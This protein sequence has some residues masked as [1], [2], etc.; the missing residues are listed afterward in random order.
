MDARCLYLAYGPDVLTHCPFCLS[1]EPKTYF[2]Y[3]LPAVLLPHLLHLF[4]LGLATSSAFTGKHG[5]RWRTFAVVSGAAVALAECYLLGTYD[6]KANARVIRPE[7]LDHFHW[8]MR[9]LR[10]I[11]ICILD[12]A[13]AGLVWGTSTNRIFATPPTA[14]ERTETAVN[15][16]DSVRGRLAAAGILRN[17]VVRDE[18]LRSKAEAYWRREKEVMSEVMDER[19]VVEGIRNA[20]SGRINLTKIEADAKKYTDGILGL[21][22]ASAT[23]S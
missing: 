15:A 11:G 20:L 3:A 10:G 5:S 1:D 14:A 4:A 19:E 22:D 13:L 17:A 23:V 21:E 9:T 2:Y 7:D 8:R 12:S 6:F 16:L 18:G